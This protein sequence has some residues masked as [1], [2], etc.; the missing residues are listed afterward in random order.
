MTDPSS[1]DVFSLPSVPLAER[2][3]LPSESGV[4]LLLDE[5][6]EIQYIGA[7]VNLKRR[8]GGHSVPRKHDSIATVAYLLVQADKLNRFEIG[9][10]NKYQPRLNRM[11]QVSRFTGRDLSPK[12][13]V[14][15]DF[16]WYLRVLRLNQGLYSAKVGIK[17]RMTSSALGAFE[18]GSTQKISEWKL[19]RLGEVL[20]IDA[21]AL[22]KEWKSGEHNEG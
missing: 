16:A 1:I 19:A 10:I 17:C 11:H 12:I 21:L 18:R 13:L 9:L 4:Y 6:G 8:I 20:G 14:P 22:L 3:Q 2:S 5:C 7:S 15:P